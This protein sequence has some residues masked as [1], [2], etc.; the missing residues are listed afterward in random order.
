MSKD[1][2]VMATGQVTKSGSPMAYSSVFNAVKAAAGPDYNTTIPMVDASNVNHYS[3]IIA[4]NDELLDE[5]TRV[6]ITKVVALYVQSAG[7][8]DST[9]RKFHAGPMPKGIGIEVMARNLIPIKKWT[10]VMGGDVVGELFK[11]HGDNLVAQIQT[12]D[13]RMIFSISVWGE[14][15][16]Y[17][18]ITSAEGL[19]AFIEDIF[20]Q[21]RNSKE[22][23]LYER[24]KKTIFDFVANPESAKL[25]VELPE[26]VDE[27]TAKTFLVEAQAT[28]GEFQFFSNTNNLQ[29]V[30]MHSKG[31]NPVLI[32][33]PR[34]K[35]RIDIDALA[36]MFNLEKEN[37][38]QYIL[39]VDELPE[40][41][42]AILTTDKFIQLYERTDKVTSQFNAVASR[43]NY[44]NTLQ[45]L[46]A[47]NQ[48]ENARIFKKKI[49]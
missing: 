30:D 42:Q 37:I 14:E 38:S 39:L 27:A 22:V 49:V 46:V 20:N 47:N 32:T 45:I 5:F 7:S 12:I 11:D 35:A 3:R 15:L 29:G 25:S 13:E 28:L 23:Y 9:L 10:D 43:T 44:F 31:K 16:L 18:S 21:L 4:A 26:V 6:L 2:K 34:M 1:K 33:T 41:V 8:W 19:S 48:F 24:I 40:D 36:A 17:N